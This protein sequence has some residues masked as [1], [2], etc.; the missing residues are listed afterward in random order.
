LGIGER[1]P[2]GV[3]ERMLVSVPMVSFETLDRRMRVYETAHDHS[4][5]PGLHMV[6]RID[7]RSFSQLTRVVLG[8][9]EPYDL[10]LRDCMVAT[11]QHLMCETGF[12]FLYGYTQSDELN[13]LFRRDEALFGRRLRKLL[14]ILAGEASAKFS[15]ELGRLGVFDARI[16]QL[17]AVDDVVDYF[18]WRQEDAHRN[19][20]NGH[21]YWLLRGQGLSD[22]EAT[23]QLN[24]ASVAERN[25]L[26]FRH[27]RNFNDLPAWQRRGSAMRWR[28]VRETG[29]DPRTGAEVE[30]VRQESFVDHE[31][32]MKD[33]YAELVRAI[34]LKQ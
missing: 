19:A 31:L 8:L 5:L 17:P 1:G 9:V 30:S 12:C 10:R 2:G 14:S 34:V 15:L 28:E 4:V 21:T 24:G 13:L 27:G 20:L 23:E 3:A 33:A 18:L 7:G 22:R 25:E 11:L 26:L 6:A 29:R 32:P 16:S